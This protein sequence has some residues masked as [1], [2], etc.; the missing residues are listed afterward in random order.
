MANRHLFPKFSIRMPQTLRDLLDT[1][2]TGSGQSLNGWLQTTL[3]KQFNPGSVESRGIPNAKLSTRHTQ[4]S[5]AEAGETSA[6]AFRMD[7]E[8]RIKLD[9]AAKRSNR[10]LN[11]EI[12]NRLVSALS[13]EDFQK[14]LSVI[15]KKRGL[16]HMDDVF[17]ES[18]PSQNPFE[19]PE[20]LL[21]DSKDA[22]CTR[23]KSERKRLRRTQG[24]IASDCGIAREVWCRYERGVTLPGTKLLQAFVKAG[25]NP[26]FLL[27]GEI[28]QTRLSSDE[29]RMLEL[30]RKSPQD[31]QEAALRV[32]N[33]MPQ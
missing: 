17:L 12:I 11:K 2:A 30:Y 32:L 20:A 14:I 16:Q 5:Y 10:S 23:L 22:F 1:L 31:I 29:K 27:T 28:T 9:E 13:D 6:Y 24:E 8:L 3:E 33:Y 4:L 21:M 7:L 15:M 19:S 26:E 25:A 18:D